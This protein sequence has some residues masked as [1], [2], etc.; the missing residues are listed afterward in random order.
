MYDN[1]L[2]LGPY[3]QIILFGDSITELAGNQQH[4]DDSGKLYFGFAFL[5]AVQNCMSRPQFST[6]ILTNGKG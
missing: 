2:M 6:I 1:R 3:R 5:P 4:L